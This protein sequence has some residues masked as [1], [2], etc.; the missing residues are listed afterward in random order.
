MEIHHCPKCQ[1]AMDQGFLTS[2]S[3]D[4]N[5]PDDWVAGPPE[6]SLLFGTQVRGKT[7]YQVV[8][9]RCQSCGLLESYAQPVSLPQ[10]S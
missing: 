10:A 3:L 1:S 6:H 4:Y 2:R 9:Y 7:H 8:S 5:K